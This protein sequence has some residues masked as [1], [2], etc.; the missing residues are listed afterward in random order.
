[1]HPNVAW[2]IIINVFLGDE[3]ANPD[4][5]ILHSRA[6]RTESRTP[7]EFFVQVAVEDLAEAGLDPDEIDALYGTQC[8]G[9]E[10]MDGKAI[11]AAPP[12]APEPRIERRHL[13]FFRPRNT[14]GDE[15]GIVLLG[16]LNEETGK[17]EPIAPEE[18]RRLQR[19]D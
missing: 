11:K 17:L 6:A 1:M 4:Q 5:R 18:W 10:V 16:T 14:H 13:T 8:R 9:W 19:K 15:S 3:P 12:G 2:E 7:G